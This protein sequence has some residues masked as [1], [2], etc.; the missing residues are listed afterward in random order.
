MLG[1]DLAEIYKVPVKRLNEQVKRNIR[2]FPSDFMF[3]LTIRE[4]EN[5]KSQ[6]VT[7]SR[8]ETNRSQIATGSQKHRDPR[9]LPYAFTEHGIAML[10]SV[11]NS[12]R[13]VQMNIYVIRAF[14]KMRE[15][16]A[17]D[18]NLELKLL[19]FQAELKKQGKDIDDIISVLKKLLDEPIKPPGPLGFVTSTK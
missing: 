10:S 6:F 18:K 1:V 12:P 17:I 2:R 3:Q 14:I 11:L 7:S 19:G 9:Y 13:A 8:N 5:L 16:L 4:V 15:M